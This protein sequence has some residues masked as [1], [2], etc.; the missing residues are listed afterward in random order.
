[1]TPGSTVTVKATD[2]ERACNKAR[3]TLDRR[4][5]KAGK[6]PPVGWTLW[7]LEETVLPQ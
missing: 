5:E 2:Y 3:D 6:E 1:M 4:Y 7:L